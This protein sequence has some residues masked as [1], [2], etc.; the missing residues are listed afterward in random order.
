MFLTCRDAKAKTTRRVAKNITNL[1]LY[2]KETG[3]LSGALTA[4]VDMRDS[5]I[6]VGLRTDPE[7]QALVEPLLDRLGAQEN[8]T[9]SPVPQDIAKRLGH[10]LAPQT[11]PP[12]ARRNDDTAD[13]CFWTDPAGFLDPQAA[14]KCTL[15]QTEEMMGRLVAP[16][17]VP[18]ER[19][20]FQHEDVAAQ[21]EQAVERL[22]IKLVKLPP[23]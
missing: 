23:G 12:G 19:L 18:I 3:H 4:H 16:V 9:S 5:A 17:D 13:G 11:A 15:L 10:H 20:L 2:H 7:S 22:Q 6:V 21:L 1:S 8:R 14:D